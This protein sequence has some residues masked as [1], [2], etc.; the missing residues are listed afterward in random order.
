MKGG[1]WYIGTEARTSWIDATVYQKPIATKFDSTTTGTFPVI[2]GE[3]GLGQTTLFEHEVGTDQVNP[4]G[5]TTTV[6]S[7]IKSYDFDL[8]SR[9]KGPD[10][11]A[12]G[13][14]VAGE[15]FLAMR[16]FVP[17]FKDL[18]GN[19]TVTLAVKSYPQQSDTITTLSP[20]T[21]NVNTDKKDTR[22]RGRFVNIK[23]EN[24]DVSESWRFG[25]LRIDIQPDGRR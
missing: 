8:Q 6:T 24:T 12:S 20:F 19:A 1:V 15:V 3:D 11:K 13:Q 21:I 14:A 9:Q 2:V 23:I 17:D 25:T 18:Q 5:S 16:R 22:A 4:D 7:F 10:G